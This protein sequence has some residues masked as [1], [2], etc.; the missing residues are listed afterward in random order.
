VDLS[1]IIPC[2]NSVG[3]FDCI[4]SIDEQVEIIVV[5]TP[6]PVLEAAVRQ[7]GVKVVSGPVMQMGVSRTL[8]IEA[9]T[10]DRFI[11]MD[12]DSRFGPGSIRRLYDALDTHKVARANSVYQAEDTWISGII[13]RVRD[14]INNHDRPLWT[15]GLALRRDLATAIGGYFFDR[16]I[17]WTEDDEMYFRI[18][19]AGVEAAYVSDAHIYLSPI[20]LRH[21]L[22][23]NFKYG[24]GDQYRYWLLGQKPESYFIGRPEKVQR[25]RQIARQ[26]GARTVLAMSILD[27]LQL[28]GGLY[29]AARIAWDTRGFFAGSRSPISDRVLEEE[30]E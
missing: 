16:R 24:R 14:F 15:P 9:A 8:G 28:M 17:F 20:P 6:N 18:R 25:L 10:H 1:V 2:H 13:A 19:E 12:A 21:E 29:E 30:A 3:V 26:G 11:M 22:R 4:A 7:L 23:S 5:L 27:S